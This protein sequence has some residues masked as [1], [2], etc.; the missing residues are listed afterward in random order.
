M[1]LLGDP[2]T[3]LSIKKVIRLNE[4]ISK[5][6]GTLPIKNC[7]NNSGLHEIYPYFEVPYGWNHNCVVNFN[8]DGT[9]TVALIGNS[10]ATRF[11]SVAVKVLKQF[12]NVKKLYVITR[13]SCL[14]FDSMIKVEYPGWYCDKR[15]GYNMAFMKKFRP[16]I[17]INVDR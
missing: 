11:T 16:D 15:I 5:T 8:K 17:L 1:E 4:Q 3:K 7:H 12:P 6:C 13:M 2:N 14:M 9:K 10:F